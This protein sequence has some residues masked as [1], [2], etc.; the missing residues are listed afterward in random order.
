MYSMSRHSASDCCTC[1]YVININYPAFFFFFFYD[2]GS[3]ISRLPKP[4]WC[5]RPIED[6]KWWLG[7][8]PWVGSVSTPFFLIL[9]GIWSNHIYRSLTL[10]LTFTATA[11][12]VFES[13]VSSALP[14]PVTTHGPVFLS[15]DKNPSREIQNSCVLSNRSSHRQPHFLTASQK[16]MYS[17]HFYCWKKKKKSP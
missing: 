6:E 3:L 11:A 5:C 10:S 2:G 4:R 1:A 16:I 14:V 17:I 8:A 7:H 15:A 12:S 9:T 13:L